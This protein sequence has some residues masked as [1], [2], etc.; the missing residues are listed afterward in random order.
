LRPPAASP[1]PGS[2]YQQLPA[3]ENKLFSWSHV[4]A[5]IADARVQ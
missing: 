4:F 5:C 1:P 3:L 2:K